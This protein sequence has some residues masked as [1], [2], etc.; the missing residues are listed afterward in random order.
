[1]DLQS[2]IKYQW[3]FRLLAEQYPDDIPLSHRMMTLNSM[4]NGI[5]FL[6][7]GRSNDLMAKLL[8]NYFSNGIKNDEIK[9]SSFI[10]L[11]IVPLEGDDES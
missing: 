5:S 10:R 1:M 4:K 2:F 3:I 6:Y 7:N 8:Y 9:F 11:F